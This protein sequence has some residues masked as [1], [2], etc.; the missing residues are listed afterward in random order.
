MLENLPGQSEI[1]CE[2][3]DIDQIEQAGSAIINNIQ[4]MVLNVD[5][6]HA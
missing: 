2:Q 4:D 1:D 3:V 6:R 5:L